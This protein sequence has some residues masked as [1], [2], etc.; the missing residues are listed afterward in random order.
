[1]ISAYKVS[2]FLPEI[3]KGT[4]KIFTDLQATQS[5]YSE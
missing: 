1:M 4:V 5:Y 2:H 3:T